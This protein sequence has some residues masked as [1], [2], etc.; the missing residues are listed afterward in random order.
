M[1]GRILLIDDNVGLTTLVS[2]ALQK[3]GYEVTAE[4][5]S[6][7]ALDTIRRLRPELIVLDVMMPEK[8]GGDVLAELRADPHLKETP[9]ILLTAL[10]KEA[11]GIANMGGMECAVL[12]KPV[13]LGVLVQE[14][15]KQLA[16]ASAA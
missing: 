15:E 5:D 12:G 4:N 10:A 7:R 2:R 11:S 6:L 8:D 13:E 9:V 14:I 1:A 16:R 3:Y